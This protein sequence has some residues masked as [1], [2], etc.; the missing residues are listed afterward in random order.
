MT[1]GL[2]YTIEIVESNTSFNPM[3]ATYILTMPS[4]TRRFRDEINYFSPSSTNY[5]VMNQGYKTPGRKMC[6]QNAV[7]D[8]CYMQREIM[9]HAQQN[10]PGENICIFEDDFEW[11]RDIETL[12][13]SIIDIR[14]FLNDNANTDHYFLGCIV[15]PSWQYESSGMHVRILNQAFGAHAVIHT[16]RGMARY[17]ETMQDTCMCTHIDVFMSTHIAYRY[18]KQLCY[19]K[20]ENTENQNTSWP[21]YA[22]ML[23]YVLQLEKYYEP[24]WS[25]SYFLS[26]YFKAIIIIFLSSLVFLLLFIY[27]NE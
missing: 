10:H 24:V 13:S 23:V 4:S 27:I 3:G 11:L 15:S 18:K 22:Q 7:T 20:F 26:D 14:N 5:V 25:M 12:R 2:G 21:W 1:T 9:L 6:K 8:L 17:I 16:P 19:Q